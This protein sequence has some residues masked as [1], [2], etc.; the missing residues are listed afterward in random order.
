MTATY[1]T[2]AINPI[3]P[4]QLLI[5]KSQQFQQ[6]KYDNGDLRIRISIYNIPHNIKVICT[7]NLRN[8][9]IKGPVSANRL[10][11]VYETNTQKGNNSCGAF[12]VIPK[13]LGMTELCEAA[14]K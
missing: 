12:C 9:S 8:S 6:H 14:L 4:F 1:S 2:F 11:F 3:R 5:L 10:C 13:M 7:V